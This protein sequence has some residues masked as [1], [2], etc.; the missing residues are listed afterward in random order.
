MISGKGRPGG[1]VNIWPKRFGKDKRRNMYTYIYI[2]Q[3]TENV[4]LS[5]HTII[6]A[7]VH[8]KRAVVI[9]KVYVCVQFGDGMYTRKSGGG[10]QKTV[11]YFTIR[12]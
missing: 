5:A 11:N 3:R 10:R 8:V 12:F 7:C 9:Y 6:Y 4:E 1:L 2:G